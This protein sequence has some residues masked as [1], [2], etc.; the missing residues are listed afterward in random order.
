MKYL[1]IFSLIVLVACKE[2][3]SDQT[4]AMT[5]ICLDGVAYWHGGFGRTQMMA[6]RIDSETLD[7][8]RC[9]EK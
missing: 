4:A 2:K 9:E 3:G 5:T 6:P 7:F 8:V 1:A